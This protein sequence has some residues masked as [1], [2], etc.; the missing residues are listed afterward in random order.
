MKVTLRA[1]G[2]YQGSVLLPCTGGKR[3]YIYNVDK[4]ECK[5]LLDELEDEIESC[6]FSNVSKLTFGAYVDM[7]LKIDC[8]QLS[9]TTKETY[10]RYI[11]VHAKPILKDKLL[12][13]ILPIDIQQLINDFSDNHKPKTCSNLKAVSYTHLRA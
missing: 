4:R 8:K 2:R 12:N 1:D 13:K 6:D 5:R 9:P 7:W 3:K 10:D 11:R